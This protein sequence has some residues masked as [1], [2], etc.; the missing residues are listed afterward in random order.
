MH[1]ECTVLNRSPITSNG[2]DVHGPVHSTVIGHIRP[3]AVMRCSLQFG[4]FRGNF[5]AVTDDLTS[6]F[7]AKMLE[8]TSQIATD[9]YAPNKQDIF[10]EHRQYITVH[11]LLIDCGHVKFANKTNQTSH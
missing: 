9:G 5:M 6:R 4:C 2:F 11:E 1:L 7:C 10:M 3:H 8:E